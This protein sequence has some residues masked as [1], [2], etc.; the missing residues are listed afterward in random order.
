MWHILTSLAAAWPHFL[1]VDGCAKGLELLAS[2]VHPPP[3]MGI[4]P[5]VDLSILSLGGR[6][7]VEVEPGSMVS[8]GLPLT[9]T[10]NA[11]NAMGFHSVFMV[12]S[13]ALAGGQDCG[14]G[15]AQ[16]VCTTCGAGWLRTAHW[17]PTR[18]GRATLAVGAA[19]MG[20]GTPAVTIASI[21]VLVE[22]AAPP[23]TTTSGE[24]YRSIAWPIGRPLLSFA[25]RL[26]ASIRDSL[27]D[28][29]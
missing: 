22:D 15:G 23:S 28:E 14:A 3:I 17:T 24:S 18:T 16:M 20:L 10:H 13:G 12:S 26:L 7:G 4:E 5:A 9:L 27:H 29:V 8:I 1:L 2:G 25:E 21:T 19:E 6:A 11:T